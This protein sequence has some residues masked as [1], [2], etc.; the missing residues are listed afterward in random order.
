MPSNL[1]PVLVQAPFVDP[2][3]GRLSRLAIG[4]LQASYVR[5][6]GEFSATNTELSGSV[7]TN[8]GHITQIESDLGDTN[9][10]LADLEAELAALQTAFLQLASDVEALTARV[11]TLEG[12]VEGLDGRVETLETTVT[13]HETR[14]DALEAWKAAVLAALPAVVSVTAVPALANDPATAILLENDLTANWRGPLNT[15]DSGLAT[16]VNAVRNALA[17]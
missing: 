9:S 15:N 17:A 14:L 5:Q 7:L 11:T 1:P 8:A 6:G 16:A 4:W 3:T 12:E 2:G 13:E 10:S